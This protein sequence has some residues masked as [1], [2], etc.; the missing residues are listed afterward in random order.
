MDECRR[1]LK[2]GDLEVVLCLPGKVFHGARFFL[3]RRL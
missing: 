2:K 1:T 3:E